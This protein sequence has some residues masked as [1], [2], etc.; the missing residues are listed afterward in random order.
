MA[1]SSSWLS[2]SD[3]GRIYG[4]SAI[5]CGK[6]L[7]EKGWRD[8]NGRATS[9]A[10]EAGAVSSKA[11]RN[12]KNNPLWNSVICTKVFEESGHKPV[13]RNLEINQWAKLLE[14]LEI[15]SPSITITAEQMA[16]ELPKDLIP[17][18]NNQLALRGSTFR[19]S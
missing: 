11:E 14:A 17:E 16:E 18:V 9:T 15:G 10:I 7:Q 19:V 5:H 6:T 13:N 1:T 4:V 12:S 8:K 2:L 3:L